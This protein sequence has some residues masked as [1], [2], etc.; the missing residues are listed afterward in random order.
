MNILKESFSNL[1]GEIVAVFMPAMKAFTS[2]LIKHPGLVKALVIAVIAL[3]G[4]MI[5]LNA[6]MAV[7]A[8]VT[9]GLL[10]PILIVIGAVVAL[11][12]I[13]VLLAKNWDTISNALSA[14]FGA[15]KAAAKAVFDWIVTNWKRLLDILTAPIRA[16]QAVITAAWNAIKT[17]TTVTFTAIKTFLTA[18]WNAITKVVSTAVHAV[19]SVLTD[20]WNAI[21]RITTT[22]WNA[23][24]KAVS[25]VIDDVKKFVTGLATWIANTAVALVTTPVN[26]IKD[27]F[28]AI[29]DGAKGAVQAVKD[30]INAVVRWLRGIVGSVK[31]AVG[32][33]ANAIK[34]PINAV[35]NAWNN[36]G[37]PG[38]S[39]N[40]PSVKILGKKIGGGSFGFGGIDFPNVPLLA[41]G[42]VVNQPTLAMVGEA[43][44]EIITP[45][46]LLRQLLAEQRPQVRVFIGNT[47]LRGLVRTEI[48]DVNTG[49]ARTLLADGV[50]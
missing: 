1:T 35:L 46:T 31:S 10:G 9:A 34:A 16:A 40:L 19:L 50:R 29:G 4:A 45:E 33:I 27:V 20:A 39:V 5:T 14:A 36:L 28:G 12:A 6:V 48:V 23:V 2:F 30:A 17:V 11:I 37:I 24:A 32:S 15:I 26:K 47:E 25:D 43:G 22:V 38:F 49:I 3:S 21:K 41:R 42:G 8:A 13:G 7:S 44:R 18:I